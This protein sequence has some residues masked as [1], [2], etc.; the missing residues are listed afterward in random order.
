MCCAAGF[1]FQD[2]LLL[3]EL[4][5]QETVRFSALLRLPQTL[6]HAE[7]EERVTALVA[8]LGLTDVRQR[9]MLV[10]S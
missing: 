1:V 5:V 7:R 10:A 3:S 4:T 9:S 8:E 6:D 2:D